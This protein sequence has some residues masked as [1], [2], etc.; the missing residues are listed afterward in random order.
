MIRLYIFR[1]PIQM[2]KLLNEMVKME[3]TSELC[4]KIRMIWK[5][6][7]PKLITQ[8]LLSPCRVFNA[9]GTSPLYQLSSSIVSHLYRCM[10]WLVF[11]NP[12]LPSCWQSNNSE[13]SSTNSFVTNFGLNDA[14]STTL[15]SNPAMLLSRSSCSG[16]SF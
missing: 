13:N 7:S 6:V 11:Q 4:V 15:H 10:F 16:Y 3:M 1:G 14:T 8:K 9:P 12:V 5:F 2:E